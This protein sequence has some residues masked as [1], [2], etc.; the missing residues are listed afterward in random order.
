M[1]RSSDLNSNAP[2]AHKKLREL[3]KKIADTTTVTETLLTQQII[4]MNQLLLVKHPS[5][6]L[7]WRQAKLVLPMFSSALSLIKFYSLMVDFADTQHGAFLTAEEYKNC[8]TLK[9]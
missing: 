1:Q 3:L 4:S 7:T 6:R 8:A 2:S 9:N 5:Q